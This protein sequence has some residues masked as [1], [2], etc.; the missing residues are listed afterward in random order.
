MS[1]K[2]N[3]KPGSTRIYTLKI[4]YNTSKDKCEYVEEKIVNDDSFVTII[5]HVNLSDFFDDETI[6]LINESYEV[7]EA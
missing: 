5:P 4:V 3:K 2:D 6:S 1:K 7:G